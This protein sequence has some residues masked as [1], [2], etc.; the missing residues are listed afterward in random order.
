MGQNIG[1]FQTL[2]AGGPRG[3]QS[4]CCSLW[5]GG[6][7]SGPPPVRVH[8]VGD[9]DGSRWFSW[10]WTWLFCV[11]LEGKSESPD[12]FWHI[13]AYFVT[14]GHSH[15][16]TGAFWI[17]FARDESCSHFIIRFCR[18][19]TLHKKAEGLHDFPTQ[20]KH[21]RTLRVA[22]A[23]RNEHGHHPRN[24]KTWC[25]MMPSMSL[26]CCT[27]LYY[28][29]CCGVFWADSIS[30]LRRRWRVSASSI[31][32]MVSDW[33]PGMA[34][35]FLLAALLRCVNLR[36]P[37]QGMLCQC[38]HNGHPDVL[39]HNGHHEV[40]AGPGLGCFFFCD[41][42]SELKRSASQFPSS[43]SIPVCMIVLI[44]LH[45]CDC[46]ACFKVCIL[47]HFVHY[48]HNMSQRWDQLLNVATWCCN[49]VQDIR[50]PDPLKVAW[51]SMVQHGLLYRGQ[52]RR[53]E[54]IDERDTTEELRKPK[55][56]P[57]LW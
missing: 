19:L 25:I 26:A 6:D 18:F 2:T 54:W 28:P 17:E 49:L 12:W 40:R 5:Q 55:P 24:P 42:H 1:H 16:L 31:L 52:T 43:F 8:A 38:G 33:N 46:S 32:I 20:A 57:K 45:F 47:Y 10:T 51:H 50:L 30:E 44:L 7:A 36:H 23:R 13:L 37:G 11:G 35:F 34:G 14:P 29:V 56:K 41:V 22:D 21:R 39:W 53:D 4:R 3:L 15:E 48:C 9:G 27:I